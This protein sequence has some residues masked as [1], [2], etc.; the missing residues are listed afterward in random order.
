M[1]SFDVVFQW[2]SNIADRTLTSLIGYHSRIHETFLAAALEA[3][4]HSKGMA[5]GAQMVSF[6]CGAEVDFTNDRALF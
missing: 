3:W 1:H 4:Q 5:T 2:L 6:C